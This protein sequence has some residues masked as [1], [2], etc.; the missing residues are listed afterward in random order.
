MAQYGKASYWDER[1]TKDPEPFDWYQRYSGIRDFVNQYIKREDQILIAGCG[2]SRLTENMFE[3]GYTSIT[4]I[5]I[6]RVVIEI[7]SERYKDKPTLQ[8]QQMNICALDFPDETFDVVIAKGTV[9]AVLCGEGSTANMAK[10]CNEV[11]RVLKPKG[12]FFIVSYG[13]PDNRLNYLEKEDVYSWTVTVHTVPKPT[14]SAAAV[15]AA[16]D[17]NG[18]HYIYIC[19]KGGSAVEG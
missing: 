7:M 17:A 12:I 10:L 6:S 14:V 13:V 11:S 19:S 4:N 16:E 1:Y 2:T 15:P 8:W 18:V 9:D 5:D 3:D